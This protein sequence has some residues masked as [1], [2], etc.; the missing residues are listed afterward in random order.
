MKG[1]IKVFNIE[2]S[3]FNGLNANYKNAGFNI[4]FKF[5]FK[6]KDEKNYKGI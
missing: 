6:F 5:K 4:V 1:V 2:L 3:T